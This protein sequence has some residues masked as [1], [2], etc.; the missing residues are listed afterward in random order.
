MIILIIFVPDKNFRDMTHHTESRHAGDVL[1]SIDGTA[2]TTTGT[3]GNCKAGTE[4][5]PSEDY[6]NIWL[7]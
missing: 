2:A 1:A 5:T 3:F 7:K 4:T 6:Q